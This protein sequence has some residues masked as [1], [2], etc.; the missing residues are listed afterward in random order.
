MSCLYIIYWIPIAN[1]PGSARDGFIGLLERPYRRRTSLPIL[2]HSVHGIS[3]SPRSLVKPM[4]SIDHMLVCSLP[5]LEFPITSIALELRLPTSLIC[6][7]ARWLSVGWSLAP[8]VQGVHMS[9]KGFVA[10]KS[11]IA[12]WFPAFKVILSH[13]EF[14][15]GRCCTLRV[16]GTLVNKI[17][18][19]RDKNTGWMVYIL[20]KSGGLR[21]A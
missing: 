3:S 14:V 20:R 9:L 16:W 8:V 6:V 19:E 4:I 5:R 10:I 11:A 7:S 12:A 21:S 15:D 17:Q 18:V 13:F 2:V 1:E